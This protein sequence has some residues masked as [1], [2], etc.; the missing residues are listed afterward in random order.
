MARVDLSV[1]DKVGPELLNYPNSSNNVNSLLL[2]NQDLN[3][4]KQF[5]SVIEYAE[6]VSD[7]N[8]SKKYFRKF[9]F[10]QCEALIWILLTDSPDIAAHKDTK[11]L[12][13]S[14]FRS[15][16]CFEDMFL[17]TQMST[18]PTYFTLFL[19]SLILKK[20]CVS[21]SVKSRD[22]KICFIQPSFI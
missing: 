15:F 4:K 12:S 22:K 14:T 8:S 21:A 20:N 7:D 18:P 2:K 10:G 11:K 9:F 19:M 13:L 6:E 17:G 1:F 3:A 16:R 5:L